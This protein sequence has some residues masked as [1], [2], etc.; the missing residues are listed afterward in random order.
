MLAF[1]SKSLNLW[2]PNQPFRPD[3]SP[4]HY[5]WVITALGAL[6]VIASMPGQTIGVNV[7]SEKLIVDLSLSRTQ[8]ALMY[9]L[10]TLGS[11]LILPY[12][13]K[14]YDTMGARKLM[15]FSSLGLGVSLFYISQSDRIADWVSGVFSVSPS[16]GMR[17]G[18]L[19]FGFF[20]IRFWGQGILTMTSRNMMGKWWNHHRG[21]VYSV[22]G[23][24]SSVCSSL[25]PLLFNWMVERFGWRESWLILGC[26]LV[27][28]VAIFSWL[29]ARDNPEECGLEVDAGLIVKGKADNPEFNIVRDFTR[30]DALRNFSFWLFGLVL[31]LQA[32][33]FT[34]YTFHVLDVASQVGF[35]KDGILNLF[36]P[37][38]V[39]GAVISVFVGMAADRWRLKRIILLMSC[40][41]ALAPIGLI[42]RDPFWMPALII[43]GFSISSGCFG[44]ISGVY[45]PRFFGLKHLGATSSFFASMLVVSSS[46]GPISFSSSLD[47]IGSYDLAHKVMIGLCCVLALGSFWADNP[48]RKLAEARDR[49]LKV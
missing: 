3:A 40:G 49:D 22:S 5:G 13:G 38:A 23:I 21:K 27:F 29:M 12:A 6:G 26:V 14:F 15:A 32:C 46:L 1:M 9:L 18:F 39:F 7:F 34:G 10:G 8:V 2:D 11:G 20:L 17:L 47:W 28:G 44:T 42:S 48:Q 24:M 45:I 35:S 31:S 30:S 19:A 16:I 4:V 37:A 36:W 25:T 43:A 41:M 33:Y